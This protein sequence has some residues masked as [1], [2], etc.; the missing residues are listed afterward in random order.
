MAPIP[1]NT[2]LLKGVYVTVIVV[3]GLLGLAILPFVIVGCY[4]YFHD[5]WRAMVKQ[6]NDY[7][8][9]NRHRKRWNKIAAEE[10]RLRHAALCLMDDEIDRQGLSEEHRF[11]YDAI[12]NTLYFPARGHIPHRLVRLFNGSHKNPRSLV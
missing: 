1:N 3:C 2:K 4:D 5:I 11:R 10:R 9:W 6:P 12:I 8:E 7:S